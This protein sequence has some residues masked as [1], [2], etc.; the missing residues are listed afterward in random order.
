MIVA[1]L[2]RSGVEDRFFSLDPGEHRLGSDFGC[3]IALIHPVLAPEHLVLKVG[4]DTVSIMPKPDAFAVLLKFSTG[5]ATTLTPGEWTPWHLG[6]R[7]IVADIS[8]EIEG[9]GPEEV[10]QPSRRHRLP[11]GPRTRLALA[12]ACLVALAGLAG[13]LLPGGEPS[14]LAHAETQ[15][16][17]DRSAEE[18]DRAARAAVDPSAVRTGL[19]GLGATVAGLVE[20]GGQWHATLRVAD[21]AERLKVKAGL[22]ALGLPVSAD[23]LVDREIE[24]AAGLIL[25]NLGAGSRVLGQKDGVVTLS[26]EGDPALRDKIAAAL[27]SDVPGLVG[28]R[29]EAPSPVDLAALAERVTGIWHGENPYVVVDDGDIVRPGDALGLDATLVTIARGYLL[30]EVNGQKKK[31]SVE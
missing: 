9:I 25:K 10:A 17:A 7:L 13:V 8:I 18:A 5:Q 11:E 21:A 16:E 20:R 31:V 24:E 27:T 12:L 29:F 3:E 26:A 1:K 22:V 30:V 14:A 28:V 2:S 4:E 6:D 23:I 19:A 15:D